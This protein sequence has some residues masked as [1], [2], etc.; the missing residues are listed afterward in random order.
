MSHTHI[1][2]KV[3]G[4]SWCCF[5]ETSDGARGSALVR[6]SLRACI[7]RVTPHLTS[8][9][10]TCLVFQRNVDNPDDERQSVG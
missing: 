8:N 5:V 6:R 10:E 1:C 2:M 3:E 4:K 9:W 7:H